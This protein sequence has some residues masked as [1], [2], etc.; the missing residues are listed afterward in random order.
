MNKNALCRVTSLVLLYVVL[1]SGYGIIKQLSLTSYLHV[2]QNQHRINDAANPCLTTSFI[3]RY[4]EVKRLLASQDNVDIDAQQQVRPMFLYQHHTAVKTRNITTAMSFYSLLGYRVECRF[5]SGP[6]R[7][8]WM[9]LP[10]GG[11][12]RLELIEVP[13]YMLQEQQR[14]PNLLLRPDVL[15]YNHIALDVTKQIQMESK[16]P[17]NDI[18]IPLTLSTWIQKLNQSS[19]QLYNKALRTAVFPP[20]QQIIGSAVYEIAF[21]YDADGCLIELLHRSHSLQQHVSS[22]WDPWNGTNFK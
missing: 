3:K 1:T 13:S 15:G 16:T 7:A 19:I 2:R 17:G 12:N 4:N 8:A 6:A 14:A 10:D 20:L 18:S 11:N 22:G 21:L 5:R 9:I